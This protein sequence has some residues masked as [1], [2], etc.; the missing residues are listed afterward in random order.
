MN[1]ISTDIYK[2][3]RSYTDVYIP[4]YI[5]IYSFGIPFTY[6]TVTTNALVRAINSGE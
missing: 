1:H 4:L 3:C 2:Y 5:C 6:S